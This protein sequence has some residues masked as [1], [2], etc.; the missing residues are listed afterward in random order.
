MNGD[1][2]R[3]PR[4]PGVQELTKYRPVGVLECCCIAGERHTIADIAAIV[5]FGLDEFAGLTI[6][7]T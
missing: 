5:A 3:K 6:P 1:A 7:P 4:M 2:T